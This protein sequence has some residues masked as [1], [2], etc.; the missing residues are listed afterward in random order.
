[1]SILSVTNRLLAYE[2]QNSSN[3][4]Q[5]RPFDWSRQIQGVPVDNPA[6]EPFR[7]PPQEQVEIFN[8]VRTTASSGTTEYS[9]TA[10]NV[11][12]NR[13]RLKWTGVGTAP[14]FRTAR[15]VNFLSGSA[16]FTVTVTPQ[17]NQSV[18]VTASS[19]SIFG[20]VVAG[21]VVYVP[22]VSTGD[23]PGIFDPMNEGYWSVLYATAN[24]LILA[25]NPGAVYSAKAESVTIASNSSFQV[26]SSAG[27]QT[28]DTLGLVL[29]FPV[30][31]LQNY[32]IVS[33]TADALE[34]ISGTTLPNIETVVPGAN[35]IVVFSNAK[36][37]VYL[38][39]NQVLSI[40]ING[41]V[42]F[43]VEP[44]LS[45]DPNKVGA[46]QLSGT[47]YSLVAQ[48]KTTQPATLKVISVE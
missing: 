1:M 45:G 3:N 13:Y 15:I 17:L 37:F 2:D 48:N 35:S 10:L 43:S 6:C 34:F 12:T 14:A 11:A 38:E 25:R 22:G 46:F 47:V 20:N 8:G 30:A 32:E 24:H 19:G 18:A 4:P 7:I 36:S 31:L 29:G 44:I 23:V 16:P 39:T 28:D 21:D 9:L 5:Q 41:G 40:S 26:F 27:V 33:V 42:A